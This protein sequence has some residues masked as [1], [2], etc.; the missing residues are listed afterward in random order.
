MPVNENEEGD[1]ED[2]AME[3][4]MQNNEDFTAVDT[5]EL[6]PEMKSTASKNPGMLT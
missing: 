1:S 2:A 4:E 6:K 5:E 3:T